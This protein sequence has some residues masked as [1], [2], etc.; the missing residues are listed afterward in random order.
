MLFFSWVPFLL[1]N[2][3]IDLS[4]RKNEER[5]RGEILGSRE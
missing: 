1:F 3:D 5:A 4:Y 2:W